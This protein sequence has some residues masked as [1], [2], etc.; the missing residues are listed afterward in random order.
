M[1]AVTGASDCWFP[2]TPGE[3]NSKEPT[4]IGTKKRRMACRLPKKLHSARCRAE[5]YS[6]VTPY[7]RRPCRRLCFTVIISPEKLPQIGTVE[8]G[9]KQ[10]FISEPSNGPPLDQYW[11]SGNLSRIFEILAGAEFWK[12]RVGENQR[13]QI[14]VYP[15]SQRRRFSGDPQAFLSLCSSSQAI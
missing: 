2:H 10:D 3:N 15:T 8:L 4:R 9:R 12:A 13:S 14:E 1:L 11:I 7:S 5:G 6:R